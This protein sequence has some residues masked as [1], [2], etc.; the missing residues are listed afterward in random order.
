VSGE[1][2]AGR[3]INKL[4]QDKRED[5]LRLARARK[6]YNV[7]VFG[8][9]ARGEATEDS[10]VDFLVRFEPDYTLWDHIGLV[11]DLV[12]LLGCEVDVS[13]DD[14]LQERIR[15]RVLREAVPL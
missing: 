11:Q 1:P 9:V 13:T 7:R 6:A 2:K 4:L 14:T 10:D 5:I 15:E 12:E 8:S 3:G